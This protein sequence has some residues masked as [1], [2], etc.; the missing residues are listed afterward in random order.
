[1][2]PPANPGRFSEMVDMAVGSPADR[3]GTL[4]YGAMKRIA[5]VW[6]RGQRNSLTN[7]AKSLSATNSVSRARSEWKEGRV[8]FEFFC[9][10]W[11]AIKD[12]YGDDLWRVGGNRLMIGA[13]L[14]ALQ[15]A[16]LLQADGQMPSAWSVPDEASEDERKEMLVAKLLEVV[17]T[18]INYFPAQMWSV[19]WAKSSQDTTAGRKDLLE[20]FEKFIESGKR[21]GIWKAWRSDP[22]F[23]GSSA[24]D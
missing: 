11:D 19:E 10:F 23:K 12:H 9:V 22:W 1:M 24:S 20:L 7:I 14:W 13:Q 17:E 5:K 8:W 15:E 21:G 18:T 6:Y 4:G 16:I 3:S 2:E